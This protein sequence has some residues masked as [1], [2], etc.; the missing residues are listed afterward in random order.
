MSV[1]ST[2]ANYG[3]RIVD[4]QQGV[5]QFYVGTGSTVSWIYKKLLNGLTVQTPADKNKPV[6]INNDLIVTGSIYNT[7]DIK[8]KKNINEIDI[9]KVDNLLSLKPMKFE[10]LSDTKN[11]IHYGFIAQEVEKIYPELIGTND[12]GYKTIN[13]Q[14]ILPLM[15]AKMKTMEEEINELKIQLN[16]NERSKM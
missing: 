14:E 13:Y 12:I 5:K 16:T 15:L 1:V 6:L 7:S 3:G 4:N 9:D 2:A 8:L 10:Y 11:K